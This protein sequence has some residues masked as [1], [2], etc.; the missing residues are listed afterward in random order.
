MDVSPDD[1]GGGCA[2]GFDETNLGKVH[3]VWEKYKVSLW[4]MLFSLKKTCSAPFLEN[5]DESVLWAEFGPIS[6]KSHAKA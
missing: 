3:K 6:G 1:T 4:K 2:A 5:Q